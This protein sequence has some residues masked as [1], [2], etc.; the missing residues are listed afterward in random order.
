MSKTLGSTSI[1]HRSDT[2]ASDIDPMA[3]AIWVYVCSTIR[4]NVSIQQVAQNLSSTL[5]PIRYAHAF[6]V[7]TTILI[8]DWVQLLCVA[9]YSFAQYRITILIDSL[10]YLIYVDIFTWPHRIMILSSRISIFKSSFNCWFCYFCSIW[11]RFRSMNH[12]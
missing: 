2:Y 10:W 12:L 5:L 6:V 9:D 3:F 4:Y 1:K 11:H 8:S 7:V